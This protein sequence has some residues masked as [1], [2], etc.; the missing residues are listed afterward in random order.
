L[1]V[2]GLGND[3]AAGSP[4]PVERGALALTTEWQRFVV[5]V[6]SP[7][8][9]V[10]ENGLF[11]FAEGAAAT[12]SYAIWLDDIEYVKTDNLGVP[13]PAIATET[14]DITVGSTFSVPGTA[15]TYTIDAAPVTITVGPAW[16]DYVSIDEAVASVTAG[17]VTGEAAG[18]T[19]ISA[20]LDG[21]MAAGKLTVNVSEVTVPTLAATTPV[22]LPADVISLFSDAF[23]NVPVDT[24]SAG[25]DVADIADVQIA[26]NATKL[27][28]NL[29]YAGVELTTAPLDATDMTHLHVDVW[30]P[31]A[32]VFRVK[33]VDFGADGAYAGGDDSEFE[34]AMNGLTTKTWQPLEFALADFTGLTGRA[35]IAQMI[36]TSGAA[37]TVY[38]DNMY[39]HK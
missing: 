14:R 38:F 9:L 35:H 26:G 18:T 22:N 10:A 12:G 33:L 25:W 16:F 13:A 1:N 29:S 21:V 34:V 3:A 17:V 19:D 39:F 31:I 6:P 20:E 30:L 28:T 24:W 36:I 4:L 7:S 8:K 15:V 32:T 37:A 5:P 23:T 11:H 2:V 27:Y